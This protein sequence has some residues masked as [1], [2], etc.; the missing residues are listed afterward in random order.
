MWPSTGGDD[1]NYWY[2]VLT[3]LRNRGVT[4]VCIVVCDGVKGFPMRSR[5]LSALAGA[6]LRAAS[7]P[8]HVPARGARERPESMFSSLA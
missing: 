2:G 3:E 8:Q 6:D 4:D 7:D 1:A 5:Q